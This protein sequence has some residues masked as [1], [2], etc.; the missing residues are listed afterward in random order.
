[1]PRAAIAAVKRRDPLARL[2][3]K[4]CLGG[5]LLAGIATW[6][7]W[8]ATGAPR[9]HLTLFFRNTVHGI[10]VGSPVKIH[11]V[12]V[13]QVEMMGVRLP[14]ADDPDHY[15]IVKVALEGARLAEKGVAPELDHDNI[16]GEEIRRGLRGRLQIISP[17]TG[18][19]YVELEYKPDTPPRLVAAPRE[20]IAEVPTL[21]DPLSQGLVEFTHRC[22]ELEKRDFVR[23]ES[24][25]N[26]RLDALVATLAPGRFTE[27]NA[28]TLAKLEEVRAALANPALR[29]AIAR[30]NRDLV[31]ARA[32]L[33]KIDSGTIGAQADATRAFAALRTDL[34]AATAEAD[35]ITRA[36]DPRSPAL[37]FA[38]ANAALAADHARQVRRL[39]AD[40]TSA[41][42]LISR[43][44]V[45]SLTEA[46][47]DPAR[48][49]PSA[50]R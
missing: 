43:L 33:A 23:I 49:T 50:K 24:E 30:V 28:A 44:F 5:V 25:L 18:G 9:A 45:H 6:C 7:W 35:A 47:A 31:D 2:G 38:A 40:I 34:A 11:G 8:H 3:L 26:E 42:G 48:L 20:R 1:M 36:A 27:A 32:A 17:M 21:A 37:L 4:I 16:L 46:D 41:N 19:M 29:A 22:A 15:A 14:T 12:E 39:C 10:E 13:G